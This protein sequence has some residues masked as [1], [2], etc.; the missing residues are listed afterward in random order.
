MQKL[1]DEEAEELDPWTDS[2]SEVT[3][4]DWRDYW[5]ERECV[6]VVTTIRWTVG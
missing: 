4:D 3:E 5:G 2:P 1:Y 6:I